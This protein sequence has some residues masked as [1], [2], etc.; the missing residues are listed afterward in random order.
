MSIRSMRLGATLLVFAL[1]ARGSEDAVTCSIPQ[2]PR[3]IDLQAHPSPFDGVAHTSV[4]KVLTPDSIEY[5]PRAGGP[6]ST[7]YR[8]GQHYHLPIESPQGCTDEITPSPEPKAGNRV[9]VHTVYAFKVRTDGCDRETLGCCEAGPFLVRAFSAR[10]TAKG[11]DE[12]IVPPAGLPLAEWSGSTTGPD[13]EPAQ[14][15]PAAQWSFRLGCDFAV[16]EAQLRHFKHADPARP[17][18]EGPRVSK[19]LTLVTK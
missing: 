18:Q 3:K 1:S 5:T 12:P 4:V 19:D 2:S 10:V 16:S 8:C 13:K 6:A 15:K 7:L 14:C 9:E 11:T 17:V